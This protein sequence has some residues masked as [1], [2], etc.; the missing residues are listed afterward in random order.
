MGQ[1]ASVR[2]APP[3]S[4]AP[5]RRG[6]CRLCFDD[7]GGGDLIAPCLCQGTSKW[8]H[9]SCLNSWRVNGSNPRALTNCCECGFQYRLRLRRD[10]ALVSEAEAQRRR[11]RIRLASQTL[12]W[13]VGLQ[14][15]I[16]GLSCATWAFD[17]K[18]ALVGFFGFWQV[19]GHEGRGTFVE[20]L[21]YHKETYYLSGLLLLLVI[22][23]FAVSL[24]LLV[25]CCRGC[26]T[27]RPAR[28]SDV[29]AVD[30][31]CRVFCDACS[32]NCMQPFAG[33]GP[34]ARAG[35]CCPRTEALDGCHWLAAVV[36]VLLVVVLV[37]CLAVGIFAAFVA[38]VTSVQKVVQEFAKIQQLRVLV[39]E[40]E[41]QDLADPSDLG[42][43]PALLL[44]EDLM[45][46][47]AMA[48]AVPQLVPTAPPQTQEE[49][50]AQAGVELELAE[51][52]GSSAPLASQQA[53]RGVGDP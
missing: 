27:A 51:L 44:Q 25:A 14:L 23:G 16:L 53:L 31:C 8:I 39:T 21:R 50:R 47:Q 30:F 37:V 3:P 9:R 29:R 48:P 34:A 6:A 32:S 33:Y 45:A 17:R 42:E 49:L 4:S 13:F 1:R 7:A 20:A 36:L 38:L 11:L 19:P 46:Q 12:L 41:V 15:L 18:A 26:G 2:A 40:Y 35:D 22:A 28:R 5:G 24:G 52:F 10:E 43:A